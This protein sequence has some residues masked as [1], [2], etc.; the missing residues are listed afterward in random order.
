MH[1]S[2]QVS[3]VK[4]YHKSH[5]PVEDMEDRDESKMLQKR[6]ESDRSEREEQLAK[7]RGVIVCLFE[8]KEGWVVSLLR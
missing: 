4:G 6:E 3:V 5:R 2:T 8:W 1:V 7:A